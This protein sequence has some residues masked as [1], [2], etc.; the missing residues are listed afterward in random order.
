MNEKIKLGISTCLL[1][2]KV[3]YDGGHKLN[4]YLVN[5]VGPFVEWVPV[6]PEAEC[7]LPIPRESMR[8]VL[9]PGGPRLKTG[10]TNIDHTDRMMKW[11]AVRLKQLDK[12]NL[13]GYVFKSRSPSS[14]MRDIKI[15]NEKGM[16]QSKG[17]GL[18]AQAFMER[19]PLL[20]VEDEGRLNDAG[21]RENF[22]ERV[23]VYHRWLKFI[24]EG[25]SRKGL[26]D[27]HTNHKL[28]IMSHSP[29]HLS[30]LGK[31][32]A[33]PQ[34][35]SKT[36]LIDEYIGLLMEGLKLR[37]TARKN[38]NVLQHIM[39]YF[40]K[41]LT[42]DEK[43]ELLGVIDQYHKSLIPLIVPVTLLNH[44]VRKHDELYLKRQHYLNPHPAEL[45]LRNHV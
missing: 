33:A 8:L 19:F 31:I 5:T 22:I 13:C 12:E 30:A 21:L 35:R 23:F 42:A 26:V 7:G 38:T 18:F 27:F 2:E 39:G 16:P 14:G 11:A 10:K 40:K 17:S 9:G 25:A 29:K 43:Q 24:K 34:A 3:R 37:A 15:Y 44:Y 1:G 6:C 45:M 41:V 4:R 32:V 20:P 28:L 36:G